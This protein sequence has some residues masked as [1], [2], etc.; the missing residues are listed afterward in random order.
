M[1]QDQTA[2]LRYVHVILQ[3]L[4]RNGFK[5]SDFLKSLGIPI[6]FM[7][8]ETM[9]LPVSTIEYIW[10]KARD[11]TNSNALGIECAE[12][13][14]LSDYGVMAPY[15]MSCSDLWEAFGGSRRYEKLMHT[16]MQGQLETIS[17]DTVRY[18]SKIQ[19]TD[20]W[21]CSAFTEFD[22]LSILRIGQQLVSSENQ[23]QVRLK[24]V[25]FSHSANADHSYY[26]QLFNCPVV[27]NS[28]KNE[29]HIDK[30]VINLP[31][32]SPDPIIKE[33]IRNTVN[34]LI[35]KTID[36]SV[37]SQVE[38]Q[39]HFALAQNTPV[40]LPDIAAN[41]SISPSTLKRKIQEEGTTFSDIDKKVKL[42]E[43]K[44]MIYENHLSIEQI[45][46]LLQYK[47]STS[48]HRA[49]KSWTGDTP[50]E[51]RKKKK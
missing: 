30:H 35:H 28:N 11:L 51:F 23:S 3:H 14:V 47:D 33:V 7:K 37:S 4:K 32:H 27:F 16:G 20:P 36:E 26:E 6:D 43:A 40:K 13:I 15:W 29:I 8:G 45:A 42:S 48:F 39:L 21:V 24:K 12:P 31:V 46:S 9:R 50:N 49:F 22:F 38:K 5:R 17:N 1:K 19:A 18:T 34:E 2:T 10:L 41:M 25:I 44:K